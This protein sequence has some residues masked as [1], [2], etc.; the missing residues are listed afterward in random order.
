MYLNRDGT[1]TFANNFL[2]YLKKLYWGP[3]DNSSDL[4]ETCYR[5]ASTIISVYSQSS[6][7]NFINN[8]FDANISDNEQPILIREKSDAL[9]L[10]GELV[11]DSIRELKSIRQQNS[12]ILLQN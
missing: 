7:N 12:N 2:K 4:A 5:N 6:A 8:Y 1:K 11:L 9:D 3:N 10:L